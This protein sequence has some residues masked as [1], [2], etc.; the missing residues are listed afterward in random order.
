VLLGAQMISAMTPETFLVN[1]TYP[2]D[3]EGT[4]LFQEARSL[5]DGTSA[6][7]VNRVQGD[8]VQK[9]PV[10]TLDLGKIEPDVHDQALALA[11]A[12]AL[13]S[14]GLSWTL[15]PQPHSP[16]WLGFL[17]VKPDLRMSSSKSIT[18]PSRNSVALGSI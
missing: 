2:A 8:W 5:Y 14:A 1:F 12:R 16:V 17:K 6:L 3:I 15:S 4:A 18:V 9:V 11:S 7:I 13:R 10:R